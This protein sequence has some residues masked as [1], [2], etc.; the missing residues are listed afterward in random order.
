LFLELRDLIW[1]GALAV[2]A[3]T[4]GTNKDQNEK[5]KR[6][7]HDDE[8]LAAQFYTGDKLSLIKVS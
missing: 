3:E 8:D 5:V 4:G 6:V 2:C 1:G 7:F